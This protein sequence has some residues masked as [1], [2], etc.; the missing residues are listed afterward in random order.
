LY[1]FWDGEAWDI[2]NNCDQVIFQYNYSHH[3]AG[4]T[5]LFM[6]T[7]TNSIFRYNISANDGGGSKYMSTVVSSGEQ[8]VD[9]GTQSY[10]FWPE[11]QGLL[12]YSIPDTVGGSR[13]PLVHN[14]T[15][16]VG[17]GVSASIYGCVWDWPDKYIRFYNNIVLKTGAGEVRFS[18]IHKSDNVPVI[19]KSIKNPES[20]KNNLFYAYQT[21]RQQGDKTKFRT[22]HLTMDQWV[23]DYDNIWADPKLKI[24][25]AD[26][27]AALRKQ[28]DDRFPET[29][30]ANPDKLREYTGVS[31]LRMQ[32][33]LFTPLDGSPVIEAGMRIR[34]G[35]TIHE[36][37]N[38]WNWNFGTLSEHPVY[39]DYSTGITA[40]MFGNAINPTKPPVG[41]AAKAYP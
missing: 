11:G 9:A 8:A 23:S 7:Q 22:G 40:D 12:H 32:A 38:A 5:I 34:T 27:E 36:I 2:D 18:D 24:Q 35:N 1:G 4:G 3:N 30:F 26:G 17:D 21:D 20:F 15:F 14:N 16:F 31:R 29:D 28:R 6:N 10:K 25:E 37:D 19:I 13:I 41:G 39:W 33:S